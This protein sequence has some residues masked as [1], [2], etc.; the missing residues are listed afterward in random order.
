[1]FGELLRYDI[2]QRL[3]Q[4]SFDITWLALDKNLRQNVAV[5][6]FY[7]AW[8]WSKYA[9]DGFDTATDSDYARY[10]RALVSFVVEARLLAE[11][12]HPTFVQVHD[13][14]EQSETADIIMAYEQGKSLQRLHRTNDIDNETAFLKLCSLPTIT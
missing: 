7:P 5:K 2:L 3:G 4:G 1:M 6:Q 12:S 14:V 9:S 13:V 10:T 8:F 11:F